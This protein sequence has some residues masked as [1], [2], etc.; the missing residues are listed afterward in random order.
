[1][2][3]I[4]RKGLLVTN[5]SF[6][7]KNIKIPS[8]S[9][10]ITEVTVVKY[11]K[12]VGDYVNEDEEFLEVESHKGSNN[13][14]SSASGKITKLLLQPQQE[15]AIGI[16]AIEI[17]ETAKK[18]EAKPKKAEPKK[19]AAKKEE[20]HAPAPKEEA[21]P[22]KQAT[23]EVKEA[24]KKAEAPKAAPKP[25]KTGKREET[26][27]KMSRIRKTVSERLKQSQNT[28]ASVTTVQEVDMHNIMQ[29]R[30]DLGEEFLKRHGVKLGIMSFFIKAVTQ[31]LQERPLVNAVID[32][33]TNEIVHRNFVDISVAVSGAKGL[34][35]PI[36]RDCQ[37]L[38]FA[39]IEQ[40]IIDYGAQA[41]AGSIAI[42]DM[43]GG[44][45]TISNGGVFG[46]VLSIPIINPPQSAVL[47]M[48]N[49]VTRP[50][51]RDGEIVAR[52]IMYISMTYDHRL[53]DGR[54]GAGFLKRVTELLDD[55]RKLMLEN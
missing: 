32:D 46:S 47:G 41:K 54:E 27:E 23:A 20:A 34:L 31:A 30:K 25:V 19:E 28:Y 14:R 5:R 16:D 44:T 24:P 12:N 42:E 39:Q 4:L 22:A 13:V 6:F 10:S 50:V 29:L 9:E 37:D 48:H 52:P 15:V 51:V 18:E 36:I 26:R 43:T 40:K 2:K 17:D 1:M 53:L 55:P 33:K 21:A 35:V 38:S 7:A 11:L 3:A 45:F 8:I 49:I